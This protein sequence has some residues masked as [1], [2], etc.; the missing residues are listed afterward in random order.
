MNSRQGQ[1]QKRGNFQSQGQNQ[2]HRYSNENNRTPQ[3]NT[4]APWDMIQKW[5]Q[6]NPKKHHVLPTYKPVIL[7][8]EDIMESVSEE[9]REAIVVDVPV[10]KPAVVYDFEEA[11]SVASGEQGVDVEA[12]EQKGDGWSSVTMA[13]ICPM[14]LL[15]YGLNPQ[16]DGEYYLNMKETGRRTHHRNFCL[17]AQTQGLD[18]IKSRKFPKEKTVQAI[19]KG[20]FEENLNKW[21][22]LTWE[23][24][25]AILEVQVCLINHHKKTLTMFPEDIRTWTSE[26]PVIYGSNDSRYFYK[27][28]EGHTLL[29]WIT[30]KET[31]GYTISWPEH[32]AK[33]DELKELCQSKGW[34]IP[35]KAKK[36]DLV[37]FLGKMESLEAL[38]GI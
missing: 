12:V 7:P 38:K 35:Q 8:Y 36:A 34:A 18:R 2:G 33:V 3:E 19:M 1:Y 10:E 20:C 23:A 14:G 15:F 13:P 25:C 29:D 32:D 21:D 5:I 31:E 37:G 27:A 28:P 16:V 6:A 30:A 11:L 4:T 9:I 22:G 17:T 26:K 24:L